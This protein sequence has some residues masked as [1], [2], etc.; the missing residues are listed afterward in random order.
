M[1]GEGIG[2]LISRGKPAIIDA[3]VSSWRG[4]TLFFLLSLLCR[5]DG[6]VLV[7]GGGVGQRADDNAT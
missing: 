4:G 5:H 7:V 3:P 1:I 6:Y 2:E